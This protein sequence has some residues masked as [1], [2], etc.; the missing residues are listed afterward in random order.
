MTDKKLQIT[1]VRSAAGFEKDQKAAAKQLGLTKL[2]RTREWPD[3]PA[4]RGQIRKIAH[5]VEVKEG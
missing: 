5:L 3:I 4:I 2:H 1:L